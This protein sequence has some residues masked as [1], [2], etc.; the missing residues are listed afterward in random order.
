MPQFGGASPF[1][2]RFGGGTPRVRTLV[3][4]LAAGMGDGFDTTQATTGAMVTTGTAV[5]TYPILMGQARALNAAWATNARVG[6]A[7]D[8]ARCPVEMLERWEAICRVPPASTDTLAERRGRVAAKM[9]AAT[10]PINQNLSDACAALLGP[11]FVAVEYTPLA[12][13]NAHW[14]GTSEPLLWSS[15]VAH[16][17]VRVTQPT[18]M[19]TAAFLARLGQLTAMLDQLLPVWCTATWGLYAANGTRG[20]Y[21]DEHNLD[22]ETFS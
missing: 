17:L 12:S 14:A 22:Y 3:D 4:S 18:S 15:T 21:L 20:F 8:P 9:K 10:G 1:P 6:L 16:I 13:A 11:I 7:T 2:R 19:G 5:G